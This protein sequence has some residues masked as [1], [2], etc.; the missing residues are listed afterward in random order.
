MTKI[1]MGVKVVRI[2]LQNTSKIASYCT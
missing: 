1:Q 2:K